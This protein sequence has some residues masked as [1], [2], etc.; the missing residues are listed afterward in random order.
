MQ[1]IMA[2]CYEAAAK[3]STAEAMAR[4]EAERVPCGV[5]DRTRGPARRPA[6]ERDRALRGVDATRSSVGSA[7]PGTRAAS[8]PTPADLGGPAPAL[9]QHTDEILAELG[10][11]DR[12]AELRASG[13]VA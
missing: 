6:R 4:L 2:R 11:G 10:L 5:V 13:A 7:V 8:R 1:P 3:L 9:G 12:I